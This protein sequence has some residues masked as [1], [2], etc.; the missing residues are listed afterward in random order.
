MAESHL[1]S[2]DEK[3]K[4]CNPLKFIHGTV[5]DYPADILRLA[6]HL[7]QGYN[8]RKFI[9]LSKLLRIIRQKANMEITISQKNSRVDVTVLEVQGSVD[10]SNYQ[11]LTD[12]ARS[13]IEDGAQYLLFD[14]SRCE[15]MS[16][17]GIRSINEIF[18]LFRKKYP[19]ENA[20][21]SQHIKLFNPSDKLRSILV[22]AGVEAFFEIHSNFET[23]I[24]SF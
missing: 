4:S 1:L 10:S 17:A 21:R 2:D 23:A 7:F 13:A 18:L 11:A 12:A 22:I 20:Q 19:T 24:A 8:D 16:S 5:R 6:L 14:L 3:N 9:G 15:Y